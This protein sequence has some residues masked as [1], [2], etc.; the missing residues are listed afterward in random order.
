MSG[1][2]L[3]AA[4][5]TGT[6]MPRMKRATAKT[7]IGRGVVVVPDT[8]LTTGAGTDTTGVAKIYI[9]LSPNI[10]RTSWTLV[11]TTTP[12][13]AMAS[14]TKYAVM[15]VA[16][17]SADNLYVVYQGTDNS[18]RMITYAWS[19]T[20]L[21]GTYLAGT[22]QTVISASAVTDRFRAVD[23]EARN[24]QRVAVIVYEASASTG[25]GAWVR[26]YCRRDDAVTW[27]KA[28][29]HNILTT[30]Y[31]KSGSEDVSI[32]IQGSD[33]SVYYT[34]TNTL[35]DN[36]DTLKQLNFNFT[37]GTT[38]SATTVGTWYSE[39]NKNIAAG[40]RRGWLFQRS[41][42]RAFF[43]TS[44]GFTKPQFTVISLLYG[45][46]TGMVQ[47]STSI[48][49]T[50]TNRYDRYTKIYPFN[51]AGTCVTAE[52]NSQKFVFGYAGYGSIIPYMARAT[53]F[54][55][56]SSTLDSASYIDNISRPL[57]NGYHLQNGVLGV[58]GGSSG[59]AGAPHDMYNFLIMYGSSGNLSGSSYPRVARAV[60]EDKASAGVILSPTVNP[61]VDLPQ[62]R[63]QAQQTQLF[64]TLRAAP[65]WQFATDSG[66]STNFREVHP[67]DSE[68]ESC[69][70]TDG[71][72]PPIRTWTKYLPESARLF[73]NIT[74]YVR[75][76]LVDDLGG[77]GD[78]SETKLFPLSHPPSATPTRPTNG[79][80]VQY[81]TGDISF[82]WDFS[83]TESVDSQS[84]YRLII[85]RLDTNVT[86]VDTGKVTS[87]SASA[88]LAI[89]TTLID[90]PLQWTVSLWD[91][92]DVQGA[93]STPIL[94][95]LVNPPVV[96][97]S[98]PTDG[99]TLTSALP[100]VTWT[101]SASG[102]RTQRA[103][104]VTII[105]AAVDPAVTVADSG[106]IIGTD[107]AYSFLTSTLDNSTAYQVIVEVQD[108]AGIYASSYG[109]LNPNST[110]EANIN[111][112]TSSG[113]TATLSHSSEFAYNS[114]Y[115]LKIVPN[116][117]T[118]TQLIV[119]GF[120]PIEDG[121]PY[122]GKYYIY[123]TA[124]WAD[125]VCRTDYYDASFVLLGSRPTPDVP[126]SVPAATWTEV[127]FDDQVIPAGTAV[128]AKL[129]VRLGSTPPASNIFYI[130]D[131]KLRHAP[132]DVT[133]SW[134]PPVQPGQTLSNDQ[135]KV[136]VAWTN[137]L[138][139][140]DFVSWRVYRRYLVPSSTDL[141]VDDT[142]HT[143]VLLHE[144]NE[145]SASMTY[146][147]YFMPV[148]KSV[149][150]VVV[151]V[152]DRFGSLVESD[153][154]S[155]SSVTVA[156]D[157]YYIVPEVPIG[158]I[159]S[160]EATQITADSFTREVEQHTLHVKD[161]G[162][163]VQVGDD[164]GYAGQLTVKLR[165]P[166]TARLE[167]EFFEY[168][169]TEDS[170][171]VYLKSPFGDVLYVAFGNIGV[172]RIPGT[173]L[174]DMVDLSVPYFV[175]FSESQITRVTTI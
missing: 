67:E 49:I 90:V 147:D 142:A 106:W 68:Y 175:V 20:A 23:I 129:V 81:F 64:N 60:I 119:T 84:A 17:D 141:D 46:F 130:D 153:I 117:S 18:L 87:S 139:D 16:I 73:G 61:A 138:I 102:G 104:R 128:Y 152:V 145:N 86:V 7:S 137:T 53:V 85:T 65:I 38:N 132:I 54:K 72:S 170:S 169:S 77:F 44:V 45:T 172:D 126:V 89:A 63:L 116:G 43:G 2:Q 168:L 47:N 33:I 135:F 13:V 154:A 28:H 144:T 59:N 143:W 131:A 173:G 151:Q 22:E 155:F 162:R 1:I 11:Q 174:A 74:W 124:G 111:G 48:S 136:T 31:I 158:T 6:Y 50:I 69:T 157:R 4:G 113:A 161:R 15:S 39:L 75:A 156:S 110:F 101:F 114:E 71:I 24:S 115:S 95:T 165:N 166:T 27:I 82:A 133:T 164:L 42:T 93:A 58:Y 159:A 32:S 103:Y 66:F 9:Y 120:I 149:D 26:V 80:S 107:S 140:P 98:S 88:S 36:G 163:Q 171:N 150:Y 30:Q 37:S 167:R 127:K 41:S 55:F 76:R 78:W 25:Q 97:V 62:L 91:Q 99:S 3:R 134:I 35:S 19:G 109:I 34:K 160:F 125:V 121:Q 57:D 79:Q 105:N 108:S 70:T 112:W 29:E 52:C 92:D 148:N 14:S 5:T 96:L 21:S 118:A 146:R 56:E 83:D 8:N 122:S 10:D 51:N 94:F 100:T 123:S 40:T 12:A